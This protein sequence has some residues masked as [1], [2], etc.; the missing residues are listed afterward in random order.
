MNQKQLFNAPLKSAMGD[1]TKYSRAVSI[2][3]YKPSN[4]KPNIVE[5]VDTTK[6]S[7]LIKA[8]NDSNVSEEEKQFLR[9][10]ASRHIA[11][12]YAK[13]A[14]YYAHSEK[15]TQ[16]LMEQ[17]ALVILDIEDAMMNGYI[18]LSKKMEQLVDEAKQI[19]KGDNDD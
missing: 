14:D 2:P 8:I 12:N 1:D 13:I 19:K 6:Y 10:A 4:K 15:E 16:E 3:Q 7:K 17:S 5:L 9:L 11:F 18:K